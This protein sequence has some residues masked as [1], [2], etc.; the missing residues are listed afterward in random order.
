MA[1]DA[2][3]E[4]YTS[5]TALV[6]GILQ[7]GQLLVKQQFDLLR[8]ELRAEA[9]KAVTAAQ[10]LVAGVSVGWIGVILL[11]I[12]AA[13]GLQAAVPDL[14][15]WASFVIVGGFF[16]VL[17]ALLCAF[18]WTKLPGVDSL[19]HETADALKENLQWTTN[20]K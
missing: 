16:V 11:A 17:G 18:G 2:R 19:P 10:V 5:V 4:Q 3:N 7:D 14:P 1:T 12:G 8:Q 13:L 6:S 15:M 9:H 20:H